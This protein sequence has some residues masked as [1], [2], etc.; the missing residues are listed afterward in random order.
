MLRTGDL[1]KA[2]IAYASAE[3]YSPG[4]VQARIGRGWVSLVAGQPQEAAA[5][6]RPVIGATTNAP[7]LARMV[8]IYTQLG[9]AEAAALARATLAKVAGGR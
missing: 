7:T 2:A 5:F 9:D 3:E 1:Q 8:D 6:W 4:N